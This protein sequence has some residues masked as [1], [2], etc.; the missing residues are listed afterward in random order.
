MQPSS[1]MEQAKEAFEKENFSRAKRI[2]E[3]IL[4]EDP[5]NFEVYDILATVEL[6]RK[7][8]SKALPFLAKSIELSP[9]RPE[10]WTKLGFSLLKLRDYEKALMSFE[11]TLHLEPDNVVVLLRSG[12]LLISAGDVK[13]G[14]KRL[15]KALKIDPLKL[16]CYRLLSFTTPLEK[17]KK[18]IERME[19]LQGAIEHLEPDYRS[20]LHYAL[21][22]VYDK[23]GDVEKS[24][25]HL[26]KANALQKTATKPWY[27]L[28][29]AVCEKS[30]Q[31]FTKDFFEKKKGGSTKKVTPIFIVGIPRCG[32]TLVEQILAS[33]SEVFGADELDY[34]RDVLDENVPL[35]TGAAY[36]LKV[37]ELS[38]ETINSFGVIYQDK[39]KALAPDYDYICDKQLGNALYIGMIKHTMPWAKVI[40]IQ[41]HPCNIALSIYQ[42]YFPPNIP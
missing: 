23:L 38:S 29:S 39:L 26:E 17:D 10:A 15:R 4:R 25:L 16:E 18:M 2:C 37:G 35:V 30:I 13:E 24:A 20:H 28:T 34:F 32:S 36:P 42:N 3:R 40:R 1:N 33:H 9:K 8:F 14:E 21:V 19:K 27:F 6:Q 12:N 22:R 31:V 7:N 41:R 11:N 5:E